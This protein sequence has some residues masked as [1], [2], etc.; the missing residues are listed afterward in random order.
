MAFDKSGKYHMN[1]AHAR[2]MD[3]SKPPS[4]APMGKTPETKG[5][6][7]ADTDEKPGHVVL[8]NG[9]GT[10]NT[11]SHDGEE[12]QHPSMAH[13]LAH[14]A[15]EHGH[16]DLAEH[17]SQHAGGEEMPMHAMAG[18]GSAGCSGY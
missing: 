10:V 14:V 2:M 7:P 13:A 12:M 6:E 18:G 5:S 9:D 3:A 15:M 8:D 1:P 17:I 16:H 11:H 4:K